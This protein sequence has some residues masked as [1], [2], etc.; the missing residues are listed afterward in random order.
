MAQFIQNEY[1]QIAVVISGLL[2]LITL[3]VQGFRI[4]IVPIGSAVKNGFAKSRKLATEKIDADVNRCVDDPAYLSICFFAL[5]VRFWNAIAS[6]ILATSMVTMANF[7]Y[8]PGYKERASKILVFD[9]NPDA[10]TSVSMTMFL[11]AGVFLL[12]A[13]TAALQF[14]RRLR[15]AVTTKGKS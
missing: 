9:M 2:T 15:T 14:N 12:N 1:V 6:L 5:S 8:V 10:V 11:V 3:L 13:L 4:I 7:L